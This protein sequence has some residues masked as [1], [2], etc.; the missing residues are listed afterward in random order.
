MLAFPLFHMFYDCC[1]A[2]YE[3]LKHKGGIFFNQFVILS[4]IGLYMAAN[5]APYDNSGSY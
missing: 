3:D 5:L 2:P 1:Y 4:S